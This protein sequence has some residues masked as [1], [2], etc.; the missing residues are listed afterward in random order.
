MDRIAD[1]G[2][3]GWGFESLRGRK[4]VDNRNCQRFF[5]DFLGIALAFIRF[6]SLFLIKRTKNQLQILF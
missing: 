1:S 6:L 2:S 5:Y 3:V 4:T